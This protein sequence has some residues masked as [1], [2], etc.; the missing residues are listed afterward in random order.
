[1]KHYYKLLFRPKNII[2]FFLFFICCA[3]SRA[4]K[5]KVFGYVLDSSTYSPIKNA[6][7]SNVNTNKKVNTNDKGQ[8][9][10][11]ASP[12]DRIFVSVDGYHFH[13][14]KYSMIMQ[15]TIIIYLSQLPHV[16]PGVT[17]T[18]TGYT[19]YQHDS[20]RRRQEFADDMIAKKYPLLK[21]N[22][23]N[24]AGLTFNLD[25]FSGREK[26]KRREVKAFDEREKDAYVNF[27]FSPE[28][29]KAY[30][31]FTGDTLNI[32]RMKYYPD[33]DWLRNNTGDEAIL[34]YI[35]DKLKS[36]Y[37]DMDKKK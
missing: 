29:V 3:N 26:S 11:I 8:F 27:R 6:A 30:T 24:S 37:A 7:V 16:L 22:N 25:Y 12:D 15:D 5:I 13:Q 10:L 20:V 35:N 36:F 9:Q 17:V 34:Y 32:F 4:Q 21:Q 18:T 33:Y 14:L 1:M 31:G 2:F 19:K 28:L 23:V